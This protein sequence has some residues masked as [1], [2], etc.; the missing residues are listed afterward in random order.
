MKS[1]MIFGR[2]EANIFYVVNEG[3]F[4]RNL[5]IFWF[6]SWLTGNSN[7]NY[8]PQNFLHQIFFGSWEWIIQTKL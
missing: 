1:D 3:L 7:S 2:T 5:T 8:E 4:W 6:D